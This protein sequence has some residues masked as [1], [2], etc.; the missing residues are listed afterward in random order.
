M[1]FHTLIDLVA[2][3]R[4]IFCCLVFFMSCLLVQWQLYSTN[5]SNFLYKIKSNQT[6]QTLLVLNRLPLEKTNFIDENS[7]KNS[8]KI[9]VS[10]T[11]FASE[12]STVPSMPIQDQQVEL[13][14]IIEKFSAEKYFLETNATFKRILFWNEHNDNKNY[15]VGHGRKNYAKGKTKMAVWFVSNCKTVLS[16]R[17]EL[18][19]ELKKYIAIDVYGTCGNMTCPKKQD[20]SY[21]STEECRDLAASQHKFYL[22]L[23][24]SLCRNY[25]TEKQS[26]CIM[27]P[28]IS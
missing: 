25:V 23:E 14:Q 3:H 21:E 16:S 13:Y 28:K 7:F 15:S 4:K 6:L 20:E 10:A 12:K 9:Y 17:N 22:S 26:A 2:G 11:L 24:N 19:N 1:T 5:Y 18:V 27:S 8:N